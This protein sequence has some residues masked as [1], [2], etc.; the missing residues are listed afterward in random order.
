MKK[1]VYPGTFDPITL[2]HVDIINRASYLFDEVIIAVAE[3]SRKAPLFTLEQRVSFIKNTITQKNCH[4]VS[5]DGLLV[6]F[7]KQH[8]LH[9]MVRGLRVASDYEY[10]A[11]IFHLNKS[12][13]PDLEEVFLPA[14]PQ[15]QSISATFVRD[16]IKHAGNLENFIP[17]YVI[18]ALSA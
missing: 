6:N 14:T 4:I 11:R 17:K 1:V 10:E 8:N 7:M 9:I 12:L 2:G 18:D 15:F 13:L 16:M 3:N 5:F